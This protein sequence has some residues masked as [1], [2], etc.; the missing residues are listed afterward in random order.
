MSSM[1]VYVP[2]EVMRHSLDTRDIWPS[3]AR[4]KN[5]TLFI[6]HVMYAR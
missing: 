6:W 4:Q 3:T 2:P 5:N 1:S